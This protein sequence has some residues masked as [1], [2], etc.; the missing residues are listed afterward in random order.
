MPGSDDTKS[1]A[2]RF[3]SLE[4]YGWLAGSFQ[5]VPRSKMSSSA[6]P[7]PS[8][9]PVQTMDSPLVPDSESTHS[10][11]GGAHYDTRSLTASITD[12]PIHWGRRYHRYKEGAYLF[13]NDENEQVRLDEQ[14]EILN[15][16]HGR[17][18]FAPLDPDSVLTVL[19]IGTGTGIWPI[20]LADSNALPNATITGVD[21]SAV[22]PDDVPSNVYFE[23]QDCADEDWVREPGS[24]DYCHV[25]FMAGSL[26]SYEDLIRTSRKYLRPGA[27][28]LECHEIHPQPVSDDNTIPEGWAMRAWEEHLDYAATK[29]LKPARPVRVAADIKTW[30]E[31]AGY[32]DIHEHI[33]K[34]P[35]GPWP[36]DPRLKNIGG[37][38][39]ANWLAGL[40]GFTYKLFG[41]DG[42]RWSRDEIEVHLADV[43][44]AALTKSVHSYQRHY[45]VY[46]RRPS[47]EE[48]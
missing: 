27:G 40:Q 37:W 48:D 43:R 10:S 41:A 23:I 34:I 35:L 38:W 1:G 46:G 5:L 28:W 7:V 17:L 13:P 12:Y 4:A 19:D 21:L 47:K 33:S 9:T 45:V 14:H 36:R 3:S 26:T 32:V 44:K 11:E 30:M 20:Q 29:A 15:R 2:L 6:T 42:L 24:V 18:F 22:Q 39:L 8:T 16:L 31:E 25:R